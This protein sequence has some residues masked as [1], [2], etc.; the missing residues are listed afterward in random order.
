MD[1]FVGHSQKSGG[2]SQMSGVQTKNHWKM[3][4]VQTKNHW[5]KSVGRKTYYVRP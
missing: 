4:G 5:K 2:H 3:S 1:F